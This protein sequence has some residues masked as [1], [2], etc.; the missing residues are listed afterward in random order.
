MNSPS[1]AER[2]Q[3]L[4]L[5]L[6]TLAIS[7]FLSL[8]R[9][10]VLPLAEAVP[11]GKAVIAVEFDGQG[12]L[13]GRPIAETGPI[14]PSKVKLNSSP[15]EWLTACPG[16]GP[17]MADA[18]LRERQSGF[19]TSW[20]DLRARVPGMGPAKIAGLRDAGVTLGP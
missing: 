3:L 14:S 9:P 16:I 8:L 11:P 10:E 6:T 13:A 12:R 17:A 5:I 19:F 15:R 18:L 4:A 2:R 20:D 7:G 1:A